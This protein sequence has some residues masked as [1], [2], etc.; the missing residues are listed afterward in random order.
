MVRTMRGAGV[1]DIR[2][3]I[4]LMN[5][6]GVSE[7]ILQVGGNDVS[8]KRDLEVIAEDISPKLLRT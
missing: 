5:L 3:E 6:S 1:A 7:I 4:A 2:S 8:R